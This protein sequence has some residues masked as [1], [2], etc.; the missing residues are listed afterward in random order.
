MPRM[1]EGLSVSKCKPCLQSARRSAK[2]R[3]LGTVILSAWTGL[4][5]A[6]APADEFIRQQERERQ[7]RQQ[8]EKAPDVRLPD[9]AELENARFSGSESPCFT[10][11]TIELAG[12]AADRFQWALSFADQAGDGTPD[13][14]LNTCLG[15]GDIN[16]VMRRVQN[17]LVGQG[18]VTT[19]IL[20]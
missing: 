7:L 15:T 12:D 6:Q 13:P 10:I 14:A 5:F 16:L 18:F 19:R 11:R 8:L 9:K 17:A 20:A 2:A 1:I 4:A 3:S